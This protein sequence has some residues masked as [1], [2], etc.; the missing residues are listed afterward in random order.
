MTVQGGGQAADQ[1]IEMGGIRRGLNIFPIQVNTLKAMALTEV[2][3]IGDKGAAGCGRVCHVVYRMAI[4]AFEA[5]IS[6][7]A[8]GGID[9]GVE[10]ACGN[11]RAGLNDESAGGVRAGKG[12][13][14]VGNAAVIDVGCGG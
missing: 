11:V 3:T 4:A 5:E 13:E 9:E 2:Y 1:G 14:C 7:F 12:I 8:C 10:I 6:S